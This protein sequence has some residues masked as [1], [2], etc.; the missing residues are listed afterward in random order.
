MKITLIAI[1]SR[2]DIQPML[3]LALALKES[4]HQV[5]FCASP[6]FKD[7]IEASQLPFFP[8]GANMQEFTAQ[9]LLKY[10]NNN[11]FDTKMLSA[12]MKEQTRSQFETVPRVA[13]DSDLLIGGG[14]L[15]GMP[16]VAEY[17]GK[18]FIY[19]AFCPAYLPSSAYPPMHYMTNQYL[20]RFI[21]ALAWK[22]E[23][24]I[25]KRFMNPTINALRATLGLAPVKDYVHYNLDIPFLVATD[26]EISPVPPKVKQKYW[27]TGP[28]LLPPSNQTLT[29]ELEAFINAGSPPVYA[30]FGSMAISDFQ[31][32]TRL[33]LKA[34]ENLQFRVVL[35]KGW[36][37]LG[38]IKL[39]DTFHVIEGAPHDLLFP[40]MAAL[41]HHGGSG[42]L[43]VAARSGKP[44]II[45]PVINDQFYF[46]KRIHKSGIGPKA[47]YGK[48]LTLRSLNRALEEALFDPRMK[49]RAALVASGIKKNDGCGNALAI[50]EN[51]K[52]AQGRIL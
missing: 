18:P 20:P 12:F 37:T 41:I 27:Q 38:D 11:R 51:L 46:G 50:I 3:A 13:A 44:Q 30:G 39:P 43:S 9:L 21:N 28:F 31:H 10:Q 4:G 35:A 19:T 24:M 2:G 8:L 47:L 52:F 36:A 32:K 16:S 23:A 1:G 14:T 33:L 45:L 34:S 5:E 29:P 6:D 26:P 42:T 49:E 40:R 25:N 17:L 48:K 15:F 7:W 22:M